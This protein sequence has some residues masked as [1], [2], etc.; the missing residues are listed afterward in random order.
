[1]TTE[2]TQST[3]NNQQN[4]NPVENVEGL[5]KKNEELLG[6]VKELKK[7]KQELLGTFEKIGVKDLNGLQDFFKTKTV[8]TESLKGKTLTLEEQIAQ[9][10]SNL[11]SMKN[12][13][14]QERESK[15]LLSVNQE[16]LNALDAEKIN[17]KGKAVLG[18]VIKNKLNRDGN[19]FFYKEGDARMSIRDYASKVAKEYPEF[20]SAQSF[21]GSGGSG[22]QNVGVQ[23]KVN[24]LLKSGNTISAIDQMLKQQ[25]L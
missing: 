8:E 23:G 20:Q 25:N 2:N 12:E 10:N 5:K 16:I 11:D 17:A 4:Q 14:N 21:G 24:E 19:D 1:V 13:L 18:E 6:E 15:L 7:F 22:G 3:E 9:M